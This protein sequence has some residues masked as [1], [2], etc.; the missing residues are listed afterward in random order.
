[1]TDPAPDL[2]HVGRLRRAWHRIRR[3]QRPPAAVVLSILVVAMLAGAVAW[4]VHDV[5]SSARSSARGAN[6]SAASADRLA[7][8]TEQQAGAIRDLTASNRDLSK[9]IGRRSVI[10]DYLAAAD[11]A[12]RCRSA[13]ERAR[14]LAVADVITSAVAGNDAATVEASARLEATSAAVADADARCPAP[15]VPSQ[16]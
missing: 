2:E 16:N 5:S 7:A 13:L 14:D 1:M 8:A 6:R 3:V 12:D 9:A 10:I 11:T 4:M 15:E